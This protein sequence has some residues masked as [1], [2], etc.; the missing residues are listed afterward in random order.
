MAAVTTSSD[1]YPRKQQRAGTER[2]SSGLAIFYGSLW[3]DAAY[4]SSPAA[5]DVFYSAHCT[6][7]YIR[8][9]SLLR[10]SHQLR[11]HP[12]P[13]ALA[14]LLRSVSSS[15][16]LSYCNSAL[17]QCSKIMLLLASHVSQVF[18]SCGGLVV[19]SVPRAVLCC[20]S[21]FGFSFVVLDPRKNRSP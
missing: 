14:S 18:V 3:T 19:L 2:A 8:T 15:A 6:T 9:H 21:A 10:P 7:F 16:N 13:A 11:P 12:P 17:M 4:R 5:I 20:C 1:I